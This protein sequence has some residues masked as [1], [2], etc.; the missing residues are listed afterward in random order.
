MTIRIVRADDHRV[1][2]NGLRTFLSYDLELEVVGEAVDGA[3][4]WW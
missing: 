1:V 3:L 4:Q 2:R